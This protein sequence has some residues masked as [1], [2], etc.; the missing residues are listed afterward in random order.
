MDDTAAKGDTAARRAPKAGARRSP[1]QT[2]GAIL[3][4]A[5]KE[6]AQQGYSGARIEKIAQFAKCN[7]RMIYHY[8]DSKK[9]L[10]V[11]VL[12]NAYEDLRSQ[13]ASL[14]ID[15]DQPMDGFLKLLRFTFDYFEKN[16]HFE[17]ILRAENVMRGRFVRR[18]AR[19][20]EL[21]FPLRKIISDLIA[22][23]E[24]QGLVRPGLDPVHIYV[25]IAALSRFH[26]SSAFSLSAV[27]DTDITQPEWLK[28]RWK[29]AADV[30]TAYLAPPGVVASTLEPLA[31]VEA[32]APRKVRKSKAARSAPVE[33]AL[34]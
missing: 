33:G 32:S 9:N 28:T 7:V 1:E 24:R 11:A 5:Q 10:Y 4:A 8:F 21:G 12:E 20:I 17:G 2:K 31:S 13:E 14:K 16:P 29:H 23:G 19:V 26:R 15:I 22:S 3:L 6:F 30:L 27:L 34:G 25:T 18:S